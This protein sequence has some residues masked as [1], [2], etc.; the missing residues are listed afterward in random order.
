MK[1]REFIVGLSSA[2]AL[3]L[4]A[5]G[6][7]A[8]GIRRI[9]VFMIAPE[10]DQRT[11]IQVRAFR[12][13]LA[14]LGWI[15][16][17]NLHIDYRWADGDTNRYAVRY[18]TELI[19]LKP[20]VILTSGSGLVGPL[21]QESRTVPIVFVG[22]VDPVGGGFVDGLARPGGN[23]TGFTLFEYSLSGKW[24]EV[25]KQIAPTVTRAA[26]I[27][28]PAAFSGTGQL[29]A[30]QSVAP[31]L[32]IEITPV[33]V[34]DTKQMEIALERLAAGKNGGVIVTSSAFAN[35]YSELIIRLAAR[36][37]LPAVYPYRPFVVQGG[38]VSYGPDVMLQYPLAAGYVARILNGEKPADLPVQ[39]PAKY[40]TVLNLKTAQAL[41]LTVPQSILLRADEVIE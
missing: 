12:E 40:E 26:V 16:G 8:R 39:N 32:G 37:R 4:A 25:L 30:I 9:A 5:R 33:D 29:G 2:A 17:R 36:Y 21:Q 15:E 27:R 23:A 6:Q 28:S 38:L 11:Q 18:A 10:T 34:R 7:Q 35:L 31:L 41:G 14:N 24:L 19:A 22:V 1:R 3:P 13:Q 20:E